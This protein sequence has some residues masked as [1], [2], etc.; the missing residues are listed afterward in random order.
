MEGIGIESER[1]EV[2]G[3]EEGV[4]GI[5]GEVEEDEDEEREDGEEVPLLELAFDIETLDSRGE[6]FDVEGGR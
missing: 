3:G 5:R 6:I 2:R 1:G 4:G